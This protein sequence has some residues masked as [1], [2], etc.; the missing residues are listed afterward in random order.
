MHCNN[1]KADIGAWLEKYRQMKKVRF[2][3]Q[4][5]RDEKLVPK[6]DDAGYY[7]T[8]DVFFEHESKRAIE[9]CP[10]CGKKQSMVIIADTIANAEL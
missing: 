6:L 4:Y 9:R 5:Y 3:D 7:I 10:K 1:C 2:D 8:G